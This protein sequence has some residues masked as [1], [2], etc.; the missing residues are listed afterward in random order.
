MKSAMSG[1]RFDRIPYFYK[2]NAHAFRLPNS[3]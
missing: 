2:N 1:N 3:D